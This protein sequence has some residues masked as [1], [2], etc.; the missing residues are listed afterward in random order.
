MQTCKH[1][2]ESLLPVPSHLTLL[3]G[4]K[5]SSIRGSLNTDPL[6]EFNLSNFLLTVDISLWLLALMNDF[7]VAILS[8][9][10]K[11]D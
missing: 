9:K 5:V 6:N 2:T 11:K 8:I 1:N 4:P 10:N 7:D 3:R